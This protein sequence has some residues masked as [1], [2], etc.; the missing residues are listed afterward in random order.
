MFEVTAFMEEHIGSVLAIVAIIVTYYWF[1]HGFPCWRKSTSQQRKNETNAQSDSPG[2]TISAKKAMPASNRVND[3]KP[4][5][6][7]DNK[8]YNLRILYGTQTGTSRRELLC[9]D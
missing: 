4:T 1:C 9:G 2:Q 5:L 3:T 8:I 6:P 7:Q